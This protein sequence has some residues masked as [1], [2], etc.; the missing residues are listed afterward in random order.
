MR[1]R[2]V[3]F[4]P[5][6]KPD[7]VRK[8]LQAADADVVVADLEDGV[9]PDRKADARAAAAELLQEIP[10]ADCARA[11]RINGWPGS[12]AESDLEVILGA[13]PDLIVVPKAERPDAIAALDAR[14]AEADS[15]ARLLLILESARGVLHALDLIEASDRVV[16]VAI[17]A[18]DLA[19][20][21]GMR[22]SNGNDEVRTARQ[23]VALAAAA[24]GIPAIDMITADFKDAARTER[25]A[26]EARGFGFAGKMIVHPAQIPP[27]LAGFAPTAEEISWA[28]S[29]VDASE[30]LEGG[31]VV[32]VDG[33]MIDAPLIQQARRI[34]SD[35]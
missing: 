11:V 23:L 32:V 25:E 22:R 29:V 13:A 20:D 30:D 14:L 4:S 16:A 31:G 21:A 3:L 28:R 34:L 1:F 6:D 18:E 33:Q 5:A 9:H 2:T 17:G 10:V 12:A 26:V 24:A 19:A 15:D 27:T 7:R 8:A 35:A